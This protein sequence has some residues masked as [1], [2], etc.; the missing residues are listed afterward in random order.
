MLSGKEY[1]NRIAFDSTSVKAP[2]VYGKKDSSLHMPVSE[3]SNEI[4]IVSEPSMDFDVVH[5]HRQEAVISPVKSHVHVKVL[6][7]Q[8]NI[9]K[10]DRILVRRLKGNA[11]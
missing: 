1:S 8:V 9:K 7:G 2:T 4:N 3:V 6:D 11:S 5:E 10:L